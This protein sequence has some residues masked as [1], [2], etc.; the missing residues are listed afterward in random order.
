MDSIKIKNKIKRGQIVEAA[1]KSK[2]K[3]KLEKRLK[4]KKEETEEEAQ[5]GS[6][7]YT[8]SRLTDV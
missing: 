3:H 7:T 6:S 1:K 5:V 8:T 4:S 2:S